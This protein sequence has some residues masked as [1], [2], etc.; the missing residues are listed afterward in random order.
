MIR[1]ARHL[2]VMEISRVN[3]ILPDKYQLALEPAPA[4]TTTLYVADSLDRKRMTVR[5]SMRDIR[6]NYQTQTLSF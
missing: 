5:H 4:L 6:V 1:N 2:K 3:T